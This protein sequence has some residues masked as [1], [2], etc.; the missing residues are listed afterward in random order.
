MPIDAAVQVRADPAL[1]TDDTSLA[2]T[3]AALL[4]ELHALHEERDWTPE[5]QE[6]YR[7]LCEEERALRRRRKALLHQLQA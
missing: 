6:L 5:H 4:Q 3:H 7:R 1:F 2:S